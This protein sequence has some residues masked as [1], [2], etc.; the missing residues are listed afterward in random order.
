MPLISVIIPTYNRDWC[1]QRALDSVLGQ[2]F[3]D[4]DV[5]IVDDGSSDNTR[6]IIRKLVSRGTR[7]PVKYIFMANRGVAAARNLGIQSSRGNWLALLDSDDLWLPEKL[8]RQLQFIKAHPEISLIHTA[9]RWIRNGKRVN[10]PKAYQKFG[11]DVFEKCLP[12]CMIGPSTSLIERKIFDEVGGFNEDFPVCEDYDF[13]LRVCIRES[14]G[15]IDEE[16]TVKYGGHGDQLSTGHVAMDYW[17]IRSLAGIAVDPFLSPDRRT[18]VIEELHRKGRILLKGYRKHGREES[19][20]EV[21][22]II[23]EADGGTFRAPEI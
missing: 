19:Y 17:R 4:F 11:G 21:L 20:S 18:A 7:V 2:S 23:Q 12:V 22:G 5:W 14:V 16:L 13:W 10:P 1:I 15:L 3:D 8:E 9:E 6:G